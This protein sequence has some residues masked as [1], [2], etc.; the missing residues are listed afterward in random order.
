MFAKS[1]FLTASVVAVILVGGLAGCSSPAVTH[2]VV[3]PITRSAA[4]LQGETVKI[5]L[6]TVLNITTGD[7]S[8]TSY[9]GTIA[10]PSIAKFT[11]GHNTS[12]AEFNP[13]VT[14]LKVGET[15]V[16]LANTDGGI[17]NVVFTI[18]VTK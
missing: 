15:Q 18:D 13:G 1:R 2:P 4:S 11:S 5:P 8:V 3:A 6:G 7:L 16:M 17:Q 12:S 14:T 9:S 10:D